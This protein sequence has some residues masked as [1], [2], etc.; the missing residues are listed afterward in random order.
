MTEK[1]QKNPEKSPSASTE[2]SQSPTECPFAKNGVVEA[3]HKLT[4]EDGLLVQAVLGQMESNTLMKESNQLAKT[5]SRM[6]RFVILLF[7]GSV[8]ILLAVVSLAWLI[9]EDVVIVEQ[10]MGKSIDRQEELVTDVK[11]LVQ[12]QKDTKQAVD[13]VKENQDEKPTVELVAEDDPEKAKDAPIKVRIIPPK[14][15]AAGGKKPPAPPSTAAVEVPLPVK[16]AQVVK[17]A[18]PEDK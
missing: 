3:L 13:D 17:K 11:A 8:L 1:K 16:D 2:P 5:N 12:S 15:P 10:S 7:L 9:F 14:K 4:D 6:L 18:P